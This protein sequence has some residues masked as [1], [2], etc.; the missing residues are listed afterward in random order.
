[1][2]LL[3]IIA[4]PVRHLFTQYSAPLIV[5]GGVLSLFTLAIVLNV[6]QQL[7]FKNP[8]EPPLVFHWVPFIGSTIWYGMDPYHFFFACQEKVSSGPIAAIRDYANDETV[9]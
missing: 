5:G 3:A 2:G 4:E 9:W 6:L 1:M 7:L 8:K